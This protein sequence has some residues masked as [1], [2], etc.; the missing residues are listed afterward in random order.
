MKSLIALLAALLAPGAAI[1]TEWIL[2]GSN[3]GTT[4]YVD[5]SSI[6]KKGDKV[7]GA[8]LIEMQDPIVFGGSKIFSV[9]TRREFDCKNWEVR[10]LLESGFSEHK[11]EG[12][13]IY[14]INEA[15]SWQ[16]AVPYSS[17][18]LQLRHACGKRK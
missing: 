11:G 18:E 2:V 14:S 5:P 7:T 9:K 3:K 13:Q 16:V 4:S 17:G 8:W 6:Q 10:T 12:S 15:K 1:A